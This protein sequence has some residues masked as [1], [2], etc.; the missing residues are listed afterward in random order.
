M[1]ITVGNETREIAEGTSLSK[2]AEEFL[3]EGKNQ[4]LLAKVNGKLQEMFKNCYWDSTIEFLD[5]TNTDA[6]RTYT[7]GVLFVMLAAVYK[8]YGIEACNEICV[9]HSLGTG[10][11]CK[12]NG[13]PV[14]QEFIDTVKAK[15]K[16]LVAANR[17]M[18]KKS[19]NKANAV[20]LFRENGIP[21]FHKP[22]I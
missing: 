20:R 14:T 12:K 15:M 1:K 3:G 2:I 22:Q 5:I 13:T 21:Y 11:Y 16:E 17:A 8:C 10:I 6:R 4:I 7:R 9:E 18:E 19:M